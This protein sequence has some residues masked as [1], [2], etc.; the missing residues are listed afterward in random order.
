MVVMTSEFEGQSLTMLE[1]QATGRVLIASDI[2]GAREIVEDG[3]TGLLFST[4]DADDLA[5]R[6][7]LAAG[8]PALRDRLGRRA[9]E[10]ALA[11]S[12]EAA[13]AAYA[14]ALVNVVDRHRDRGG[15][16]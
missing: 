2:D 11:H 6:T 12:P 4:G 13:A 8:D 1:A 15:R 9:R 10:A 5:A 7:L 16:R 3:S 14:E